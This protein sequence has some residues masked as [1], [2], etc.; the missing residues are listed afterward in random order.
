MATFYRNKEDNSIIPKGKVKQNYP[1]SDQM[2]GQLGFDSQ[3]SI[4]EG[5]T[6]STDL[7][8]IV[9]EEQEALNLL[10]AKDFD[11]R[12]FM[13]DLSGNSQKALNKLLSMQSN[14]NPLKKGGM[15][16]GFLCD[17]LILNTRSLFDTQE[18]TLFDIIS[19][20]VSTRP[21]DESYVI[22]SSDIAPYMPYKD[23]TYINTVLNH[24]CESMQGKTIP[25]DIQLPNGK[26][27]TIG[28]F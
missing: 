17:I 3:G 23:K 12:N 7:V 11:P 19:A 24:S 26:T 21:E 25:F 6:D 14:A 28:V 9:D 13:N 27:K 4:Y 22:Y 18:N 5:Q 10:K 15:G 8:E 1:L 16:V 20:V 2:S